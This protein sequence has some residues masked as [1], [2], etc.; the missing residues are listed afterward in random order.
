MRI[1]P[2]LKDKLRDQLSLS[3]KIVLK[4]LYADTARPLV[5]LA[6]HLKGAKQVNPV[7]TLQPWN[8]VDIQSTLRAIYQKAETGR[9]PCQIRT[10]I[11]IP[12]FNKVDFTFQ[13]L[14][15]L[16]KEV[17]LTTNETV[18]INNASTDGTTEMLGLFKNFV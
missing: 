2:S 16:F 15:S 5:H 10:S 7:P 1:V 17:D 6:A 3:S 11:I 13:C 18:I 9:R 14:Q 8:T 4:R 12:V